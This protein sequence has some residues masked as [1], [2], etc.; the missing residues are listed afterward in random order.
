MTDTKRNRVQAGVPTGGQF[1]SEAK[2]ENPDLPVKATPETHD[3]KVERHSGIW[4]V[5]RRTSLPEL[6]EEFDPTYTT[7]MTDLG[8]LPNG[9]RVDAKLALH[10]DMTEDPDMGDWLANIEVRVTPKGTPGGKLLR[11]PTINGWVLSKEDG[12]FGELGR[13]SEK[14]TPPS[15]TNRRI[16]PKDIDRAIALIDGLARRRTN[17]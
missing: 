11:T 1:A 15:R 6:E 2:G 9:D 3:E 14:F 8:D 17:G 7:G 16:D 4:A 5:I 10:L 13:L 12:E